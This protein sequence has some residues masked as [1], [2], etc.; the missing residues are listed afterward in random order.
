MSQTRSLRTAASLSQD[1]DL[2]AAGLWTPEMLEA[3][4]YYDGSVQ[5]LPIVPETLKQRYLTAFEID[6]AWLIECASRR[7]KWIDMGQRM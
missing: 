1:N 5:Q 3:L 7:Q 6:P 2:K 4:K